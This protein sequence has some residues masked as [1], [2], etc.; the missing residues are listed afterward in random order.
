[1]NFFF[2]SDLHGREEL[3]KKLFAAIARYRP[4]A[5]FL[6]GD[7]LPSGLAA[8]G[9]QKEF[10]D[11]FLYP[12]FNLLRTVFANDYPRI[13][14]ILG[15]DDSRLEEAAILQY[16]LDGLWEYMH[17]KIA[18]ISGFRVY[19]YSFVPPT[20]FHL[21]DWEKY[22]V[23]RH[24]DPGCIA[25]EAGYR[26]IPVPDNEIKYGTIARDLEEFTGDGDLDRSIFLFHA[27]PYKS[28]LDRAALDGKLIDHVPLDVHVGSIAI[29]RF[30]RNRQPLLTLH[31]HVHESS[32]LT[33]VW[34]EKIG[35]TVCLSAAYEG[36]ELALIRFE[37]ENPDQAI[38]ELI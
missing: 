3:Y 31:G 30:I 23:S 19:G 14:L 37:P 7:L 18:E 24:V 16:D 22:D 1:M 35:R 32:R 38:R 4:D 29:E 26:T 9:E 21:K 33:G 34:S 8:S 27:P 2:V 28:R 13:F 5:V 20:P 11:D 25:P 17:W 10:I 12:E 36:P 15:N 6:G